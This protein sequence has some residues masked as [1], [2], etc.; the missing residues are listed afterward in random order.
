MTAQRSPSLPRSSTSSSQPRDT[1][2]QHL[3]GRISA[4]IKSTIVGVPDSETQICRFLPKGDLTTILS[5]Q[6]LR[7]Y[8]KELLSESTD[9]VV[10]N[11]LHRI[12]GDPECNE[13]SRRALLA[14]F[15]Y[16]QRSGLLH[17]F[18]DWLLAP[19]HDFPSDEWLPFDQDRLDR[20]TLPPRCHEY[21]K[22]YQYIF[23]PSTIREDMHQT[24]HSK[25]RLPYIGPPL[26][27]IDGSSG[28]VF[29]RK[30]APGHWEEKRKN[31]SYAPADTTKPT[32]LAFKVF[33]G[34]HTGQEA[35]TNFEIE[36]NMLEDLRNGNYKHK[37]ILLDSGSFV[38]RDETRIIQHCL[39][40][41]RATCT[42]EEF[43]TDEKRGLKSWTSSLLLTNLVGLVQALACLHDNLDTLHL[44]IKPDNILVFDRPPIQLEDG[45]LQEA[46]FEWKISDFGLA[47]K[48]HAKERTGPLYD[49][50]R[51]ASQSASLYATRPAGRFQA[52]EVQRRGSSKASRGSDVWSMGC[53]ILMVLGFLVDTPSR[54]LR[55]LNS[56]Q[57]EIVEGG[58]TDNLFYV[59]SDTYEWRSVM[60]KEL[61]RFD[62]LDEPDPVI[63]IIPEARQMEA[64]VH[65]EVVKWSNQLFRW[66][67]DKPEQP[68][69]KDAL[70]IVFLRVL[71]IEKS[72]R[73]GA[74]YLSKRLADVRDR[75]KEIEAPSEPQN[76]HPEPR[77]LHSLEPDDDNGVT[78][79]P[80]GSD[81]QGGSP[82][83]SPIVEEPQPVALDHSRLCSA[84]TQ[85]GS[86]SPKGFRQVI[87]EELI[88]DISQV[89]EPCPL[90]SC[91]SHPI[92][93]AI[94]HKSYDALE[95]LL[96]KANSGDLIIPCSGCGDRTPL[97]EACER[98]GD[99][100]AL[101]YFK[102]YKSEFG[103]TREFYDGHKSNMTKPAKEALR[104]LLQAPGQQQTD[105][106]V[107]RRILTGRSNGS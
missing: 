69:L 98:P 7:T 62:Y 48:R 29:T 82:V 103:V 70:G 97:E 37:M 6:A 74:F 22:D 61:Y 51:S 58:V 76:E 26:A 86:A 16:H 30:V 104:K 40:F 57:L 102:L 72:Q 73:I 33:S 89:R 1:Q 3:S 94:R 39:I 92:N 47:R 28:T 96:I 45:T 14:L 65:P 91:Q 31:G 27:S 12:I 95:E 83:P 106:S 32:V 64:A 10:E 100:K 52:P 59:T 107:I 80:H 20:T 68:I 44:D 23:I 13:P 36:R 25:E 105:G 87:K 75:W 63:G 15:L 56:L 41:E 85:T 54:V 43:L 2:Q 34:G 17:H 77:S 24:F 46:K 35:E 50:N 55:L 78:T 18:K 84:I 88:R 99:P 42:L 81:N 21:I 67:N 38:I 53:V 8:L 71:L 4:S 90:L 101:K 11:A 66:C 60:I 93:V 5:E 19:Q 9:E 79:P 49:R